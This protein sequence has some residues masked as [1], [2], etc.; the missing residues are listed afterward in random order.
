MQSGDGCELKTGAENWSRT[1][2]FM[3]EEEISF[4]VRYAFRGKRARLPFLSSLPGEFFNFQ[5]ARSWFMLVLSMKLIVR[6]PHLTSASAV[7]DANVST[8]SI[9]Y[10]A[11]QAPASRCETQDHQIGRLFRF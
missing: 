11:V 1:Y 2:E 7:S 6:F 9:T 10:F 8:L 5:V 4:V 3:F